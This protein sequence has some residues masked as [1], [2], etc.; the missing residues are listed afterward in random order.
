M[1]EYRV[2]TEFDGL[3]GTE[4]YNYVEA[5]SEEEAIKIALEQR[6]SDIYVT[7]CKRIDE[8]EE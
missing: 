7:K 4:F 6:R 5:D 3:L 8:E 1:A 2:T